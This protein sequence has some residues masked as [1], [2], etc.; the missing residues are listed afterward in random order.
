M[1]ARPQ[2]T[3]WRRSIWRVARSLFRWIDRKIDLEQHEEAFLRGHAEF[4]T[5]GFWHRGFF[6]LT[7]ERLAFRDWSKG[8]MSLMS[9]P[10][11]RLDIS[12][13]SI[14]EVS[15]AKQ[16]RAIMNPFPAACLEVHLRTGEFYCF[17]VEKPAV[18][19]RQ[20]QDLLLNGDHRG[21]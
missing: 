15:V 21:Q 19:A 18:W 4:K 3:G 14:S 7:S 5:K 16:K 11:Q 6:V 10:P 8:D 1:D 9:A 17:R 13:G 12:L 20:V 2:L